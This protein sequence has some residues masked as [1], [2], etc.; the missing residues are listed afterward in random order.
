MRSVLQVE[1][2]WRC[3]GGGWIAAVFE[4]RAQEGD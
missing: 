4:E 3:Y 2:G 1:E